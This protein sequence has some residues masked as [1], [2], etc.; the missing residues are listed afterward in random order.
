MRYVEEAEIQRQM[1]RPMLRPHVIIVNRS[2]AYILYR[3]E[4]LTTR[5]KS[6]DDL[7]LSV[8]SD[9]SLSR[10]A[11]QGIMGIERMDTDGRK[12]D[13]CG[14]RGRDI[15]RSSECIALAE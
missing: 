4:A 6:Q 10:K 9:E 3:P 13:V 5:L 15:L 8:W 12:H 14:K 11:A 1:Q 2:R 7:I